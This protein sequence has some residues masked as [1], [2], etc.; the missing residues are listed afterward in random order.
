MERL[1]G[2]VQII[3][4]KDTDIKLLHKELEIPNWAPWLAASLETMKTRASVFPAGQLVLTENTQPKVS[5]STNRIN[6]NG[7]I[8]HLP[9]W[10]EV[11]GDMPNYKT[12]YQPKGNTLVLMSMNVAPME[13]GK[14]YARKMLEEAKLLAVKLGIQNLIG[15]FRPSEYGKHKQH[16]LGNH[17]TPLSFEQYVYSKRDDG[18]PVDSWLRNL[19]R[20]GVELWKVDDSAMTVTVSFDE[21][22][23]YIPQEQQLWYVTDNTI[24]T[25]QVG[26]WRVDY[27]SQT[28]T[29]QEKNIWG[30]LPFHI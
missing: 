17:G 8:D 5:L 27:G 30:G 9:S 25:D 1:I 13:Q 11:A 16:M 12:T 20:N 2:N 7:N 14:G 26:D 4:W 19:T 28:V 3:S 29:Y 21:F 22:M 6:W 24:V 15:S 23:G 10:D 18:L